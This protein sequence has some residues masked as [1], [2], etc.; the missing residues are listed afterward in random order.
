MSEKESHHVDDANEL[1]ATVTDAY[2]SLYRELLEGVAE[3]SSTWITSG[4]RGGGAYGTVADLTAEQ[5][6]RQLNG[7]TVAAHVE[8]LRWA[9]QL[10]NDEYD[11]KHGA[12]HWSESWL[13]STVDAAAWD[14]LRAELRATGERL[15]ANLRRP[16]P[17]ERASASKSLLFSFGHTAYHLGALRQ[18]RKQLLG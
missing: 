14:R 5:A 1:A 9:M 2:E 17:W 3:G 11:G 18:L 16:A 10:L 15:L 6:S 12:Q 13:V 4:G 7:T 8:H